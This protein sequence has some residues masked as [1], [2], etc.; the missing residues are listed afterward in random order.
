MQ[1]DRIFLFASERTQDY[2][3]RENKNNNLDFGLFICHDNS[4]QELT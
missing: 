1:E 2:F 3:G 4:S